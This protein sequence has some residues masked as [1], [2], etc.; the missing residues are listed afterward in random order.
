MITDRVYRS[1]HLLPQKGVQW[2]TGSDTVV[3]T[4]ANV[5]A[6]DLS[7]NVPSGETQLTSRKQLSPRM[8]SEFSAL[9][10]VLGWRTSIKVLWR[11]TRGS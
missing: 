8:G 7:L 5:S 6:G 4:E 1:T 3:I 11:T 9:K 2:T 10:R